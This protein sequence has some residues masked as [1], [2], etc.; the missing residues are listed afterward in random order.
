MH[1]LLGY[2]AEDLFFHLLGRS[3]V[4][5]IV[6][7]FKIANSFWTRSFYLPLTEVAWGSSYPSSFEQFP[8]KRELVHILNEVLIRNCLLMSYCPFTSYACYADHIP[9]PKNNIHAPCP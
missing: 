2:D 9:S 3:R 8:D 1:L 5:D 7:T 6:L 4:R